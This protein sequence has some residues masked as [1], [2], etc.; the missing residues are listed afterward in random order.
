MSDGRARRSRAASEVAAG[1]SVQ[2]FWWQKKTSYRR[3]T[4]FFTDERL[5]GF[6]QS[7]FHVGSRRACT[8]TDITFTCTFSAARSPHFP[9]KC[10][11]NK[12]N[13]KG[14]AEMRTLSSWFWGQKHLFQDRGGDVRAV[15][16][17]SELPETRPNPGSLSGAPSAWPLPAELFVMLMRRE[18]AQ[19]VTL[20]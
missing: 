20:E 12:N 10:S 9:G 4:T 13:K 19:F 1:H 18:N 16:G 15:A 7:S 2:L 8:D 5:P 6:Y 14:G 17:A 3:E 11:T